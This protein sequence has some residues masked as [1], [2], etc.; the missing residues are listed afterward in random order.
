MGETKQLLPFGDSTIIEQVVGNLLESE[1]AETIVVLG[2]QAEK[3]AL[4]LESKPVKLVRNQN[5]R[6]GIS[7]SIKCG[8][9]HVSKT[10]TAVLIFLGD[11]PLIGKDIINRLVAEFPKSRR[12]II[13]PAYRGRRGHPVLFDLKYRDELYCLE[14]DTGARKI[15]EAHPEDVFEVA[16]DSESVIT[17]IDTKSDYQPYLI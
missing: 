16:A 14:G 8:L 12:G 2:H 13:A 17:D 1:V 6:K 3:L 11:Q 10:S 4:Q 15:V 7:S 9:D 5:Y